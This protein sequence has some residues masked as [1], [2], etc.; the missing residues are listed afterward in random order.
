MQLGRR[1]WPVAAA[2]PVLIIAAIATAPWSAE[3]AETSIQD[4]AQGT[5]VGQVEFSAG[6]SGCGVNCAKASDGSYLWT[7]VTGAAATIRFTGHQIS[8]WGV[9]E[10]WS[11]IAT[12]TIDGGAPADIDE[13]AATATD[14]SVK[15]WTSPTLA[16]GPHTL[17]LRMTNRKNPA[18]AGG[19]AFTFDRA[20]VVS[21][22]TPP[23]SPNNARGATVSASPSLPPGAHASGLPWSDGGYFMHDPAQATAFADW[24]GR[25]VDN[26]LSFA[27]RE[28]WGL[29]LEDWWAR[30]VP[31]S[32]S[33]ARDDFILAVPLWTDDGDR[34]SEANWRQLAGEIAAV[35]PDAYVRLG[36]EMNC[37]TSLA[38]DADAW[39]TQFSR[40]AT[41]LKAAAPGL[42]IV[43]NPNEGASEPGLVADASTL[44][45][46]G[47]VDVVAIDAYDWYPAYDTAANAERHFTKQ[48]GWN[49]WYDFAQSEGLPFAL[50]EFGVAGG[51]HPD[52][53]GDD[54]AYFTS[55][56]NWLSAKHAA[57]P[58]SI[59]FV[60]LF[61]ESDAYCKC[62]VY[63]AAP[64]PNAA[65]RYK[66]VIG[67][68]A[69]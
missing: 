19:K 27:S 26:I 2:A 38:T 36:W 67:S 20:D 42:R 29:L 15:L 44:F 7:E 56:Y 14:T 60:S 45:V 4:T 25:P 22:S 39:R 66:A 18:S 61:N 28:N 50:G 35:D 47:K 68:L 41:L 37:C 52:S 3:A 48:Y 21:G 64:N 57:R 49:W 46:A 58:G 30:S 54:P 12:A 65:A 6:W 59:A 16:E 33:P 24:R 31:P 40:A 17:V 62:N 34:G 69:R 10:P 63:P 8:L 53:G 55:V 43:F 9:K 32:F 5:G 13:H 23:P 51:G 1:L 11:Y